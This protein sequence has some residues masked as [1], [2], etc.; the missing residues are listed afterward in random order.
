M[1]ERMSRMLLFLRHLLCKLAREV[2]SHHKCFSSLLSIRDHS[3]PY[4]SR[5]QNI[6]T[7]FTH[8]YSAW[9]KGTIERLNKDVR[10]Y[11]PKKTPFTNNI[12]HQIPLIENKINHLPRKV[13]GYL[14]P[15][16]FLFYVLSNQKY[17]LSLHLSENNFIVLQSRIAW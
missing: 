11:I 7:F 5:L 8:P 12:L 6:S 17:S 15:S 16:E 13:L 3:I 10:Y 9:Q 1:I 14:S 4:C 2:S